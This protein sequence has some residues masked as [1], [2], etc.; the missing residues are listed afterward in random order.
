MTSFLRGGASLMLVFALSSSLPAQT[1][2]GVEILL[3]KARSLEA[4]GRMDLAAQNWR[5]VLLV[6]PT[7]TEA[8][9]GLA[10]Y[11]KENGDAQQERQ[12]LDRLRKINPKDPAIAAIENMHVITP[13]ERNRLEEAGRLAM[14]HKPDEA[15]AIYHQVFGEEPS[16]GEIQDEPD[17][18]RH[19]NRPFVTFGSPIRVRA[20]A[21]GVDRL[22]IQDGDAIGSLTLANAVRLTVDSRLT[23]ATSG[24]PDGRSSRVFG[25]LPVGTRFTEQTQSGYGGEAQLS[26]N[27]LGLMLGM[28][29]RGFFVEHFV[30]GVRL[31]L[32]EGPVMLVAVREPM[33]DSLLSYAGARDPGTGTVWGGV[34]SDSVSLQLSHGASGDGQYLSAR[35]AHLHGKNVANNWDV[36][37]TGG[38]YWRVVKSGQGG[39]S[40]GLNV[41]GM[42]YDKNQNFFTLR[43]GGYFSPQFYALASAPVS[44]YDRTDRVE[45]EISAGVGVQHIVEDAS[46]YYPTIRGLL[47][48]PTYQG[49]TRT[50]PNYNLSFRV[51]YRLASHV[52][53]IAYATANNARDY[54]AQTFVISL[55]ILMERLPTNA[56]LR[57]RSVPD[58]R[59]RQPFSFF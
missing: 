4:R 52:S 19:R 24:T 6:V 40:V 42:H 20:G 50:G 18:V 41:T 39:L 54:A 49:R 36:D 5:Q 23:N 11:A 28:T 35:Y 1:A 25:T 2:D 46:P 32:A 59:G 15:M 55:R 21:A 43:Q 34:V 53:L 13:Q 30:G 37:G 14:Q 16:S 29:P 17:L 8:L 7:E 31:G 57:V 56:G 9:A 48:Q 47:I 44:W 58:W 33:K 3:S 51:D 38:A 26:T 12:Y 10:R 45:Y 27:L 22:V